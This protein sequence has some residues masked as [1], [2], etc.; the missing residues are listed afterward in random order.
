[1]VREDVFE[2]GME[3]AEHGKS[4]KRNPYRPGTDNYEEWDDGWQ[5]WYLVSCHDSIE[6]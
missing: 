4:R 1:M 5:T 3:A 6:T 2:E